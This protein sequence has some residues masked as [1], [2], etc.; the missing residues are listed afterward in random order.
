MAA[1]HHGFGQNKLEFTL[2]LQL[3]V[4][5]NKK[6]YRRGKKRGVGVE[7]TKKEGVTD[8][9]NIYILYVDA[10]NKTDV[11]GS[12]FD[13]VSFLVIQ[14]FLE[15]GNAEVACIK[16]IM[17]RTSCIRSNFWTIVITSLPKPSLGK[18]VSAISG[19]F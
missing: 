10:Q 4:P 9:A 8:L 13:L 3:S 15:S 6:F 18:E 12:N 16:V 19:C 1:G 2:G 17:R 5:R 7:R 11:I 14:I